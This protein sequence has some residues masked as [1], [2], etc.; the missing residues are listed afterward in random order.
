MFAS[1]IFWKILERMG[2]SSQL[3][4]ISYSVG[5]SSPYVLEFSKKLPDANKPERGGGKNYQNLVNIVYGY[6]GSFSLQMPT[7]HQHLHLKGN[8]SLLSFLMSLDLVQIVSS[9]RAKS[10]LND[11]FAIIWLKIR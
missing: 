9:S 10:L 1:S 8:L 4:T 11:N 5:Y 2:R 3:N 7:R 6:P